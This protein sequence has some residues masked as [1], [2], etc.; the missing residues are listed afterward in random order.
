VQQ[1]RVDE[2]LHGRERRPQLVGDEGQELALLLIGLGE[3]R[4]HGV[5]AL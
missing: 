3:L 4:G 2:P 5:L 1:H